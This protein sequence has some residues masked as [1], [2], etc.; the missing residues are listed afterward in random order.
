MASRCIEACHNMELCNKSDS[1]LPNNIT[2]SHLNDL[3]PEL[4]SSFQARVAVTQQ[5]TDLK[6]TT[7]FSQDPKLIAVARLSPRDVSSGRH[8]CGP[9]ES[10]PDGD[11]ISG[12]R[13]QT[14]DEEAAVL[15]DKKGS[16]VAHETERHD[17]GSTPSLYRKLQAKCRDHWVWEILACVLAVACLVAIIIILALR[18]NHPVPNWPNMISI[19]SWVSIFTAIMK[20]AIMLPVGEGEFH[21]RLGSDGGLL[22]LIDD[23]GISQL[24]WLWFKSPRPLMDM[25]EF[26]SATRGPW[27]ALLLLFSLRGQ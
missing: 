26:D 22:L 7:T 1:S 3:G 14:L 6:A 10:L 19:N 24:K 12:S 8:P 20:A 21:G 15:A 25:E 5:D 17:P 2:R 16:T 4:Q 18:Q 11:E 23:V 27:G 13:N 9:S